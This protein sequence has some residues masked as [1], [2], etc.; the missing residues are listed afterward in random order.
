MRFIGLKRLRVIV[1]LLFFG[2]TGWLFLDVNSTIPPRWNDA[3]L[4]LQFTPSLLKFIGAAGLA[5]A[6]FLFVLLLTLLFGRVFCSTICPLGTLQDIV[7]RVSERLKK[8][9][10]VRF[11]Y[12]KAHTALRYGALALTAVALAYGGLWLV[13]LLDP[14]S[15]FGRLIADLLRPIYVGLNNGL[16]HT[17][18]TVGVYA[19]RPAEWKA[20]SLLT[21]AFPLGFLALLLWLCVGKGRLFCN[22]LCPVGA[23]LG[24]VAKFS[25][26]KIAIDPNACTVCAECSMNCKARCIRLKTKEIDF[27]RCVACFDCIDVCPGAGIGYR[28]DWRHSRD[29]ASPEPA[30][31]AFLGKAAGGLAL[32]LTLTQLNKTQALPLTSP[33]TPVAPPGAGAIAR[34]NRT[35]TACHLCVSAC[36][37]GVLQPALLEY[38]LAGLLQPRMDYHASYCNY[39][40]TRC[41]DICPTGALQPLDRANKQLTQLGVARFI[42][43]KCIVYTDRTACGACVEHCP[44][45]AVHMVPY[46]GALT[47]PAVRETICIGCGACEYACPVRPER[48]IVVA[49]HA[50][51]QTAQ[52]PESQPLD[53]RVGDEFPF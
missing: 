48:A 22:T 24:L 30:R 49:G 35:C 45:K 52:A 42:Q 32:G 53:V 39:D 41:G 23:L 7:I 18:E 14:F 36:P 44:T 37:T 43:E 5:A 15:N 3:A 50:V 40:C 47:I 10:R 51:Q 33:T 17:L 4:H 20:P 6:G 27:S 19:L 11:R 9:K 28:L 46:Q 38:G 8:P 21:L 12:A 1:A 29:T 13:G 16:A 2:A 31:R 25:L 34:F 26:F